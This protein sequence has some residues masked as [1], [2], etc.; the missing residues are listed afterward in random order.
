MPATESDQ[1]VIQYLW[2]RVG[3]RA[4]DI[5][6]F[7][8]RGMVSELLDLM[9]EPG[10]VLPEDAVISYLEGMTQRNGGVYETSEGRRYRISMVPRADWPVGHLG[11]RVTMA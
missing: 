8:P 5:T 2:D 6:T 9:P 1:R 4:S 3:S 7:V 10:D 11:F